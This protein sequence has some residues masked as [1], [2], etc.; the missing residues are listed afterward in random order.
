MEIP[1]ETKLPISKLASIFKNTTASYKYF[2]FLSILNFVEKGE[3]IIFKE[4]LF[5]S[6]LTNAWHPIC[7]HNLSFGKSDIIGNKINSI[8]NQLNIQSNISTDRLKEILS[9]NINSSEIAFLNKN[10]PFKFL[11]PW[12]GSIPEKEIENLSQNFQENVPYAL[13]KHKIVINPKWILYLSH[14]NKIL[15]EFCYWN[16]SSFLQTRNPSVPNVSMKLFPETNRNALNK[17]RNEFWKLTF[18]ELGSINCIFTGNNLTI[19]EN[20]FAIDHFI[21]Y[22]FVTHDLIWN[23]LPI[24]KTFNSIKSNKI[25]DFSNHFENFCRLQNTAFEIYKNKNPDGKYLEEYITIFKHENFDKR[26]LKETIEPLTMIALN[27]GFSP[28]A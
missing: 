14:N 18:D 1:V 7:N 12:Y 22:S 26:K 27:N 3:T 21:P 15:R 23:L 4:D 16:L 20:N 10:V 11:S 6:M 9:E 19:K 13:F 17:Q 24:D 2:W 25:P 8:N 28:L 5:L